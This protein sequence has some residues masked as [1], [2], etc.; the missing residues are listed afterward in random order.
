MLSRSEQTVASP[1]WGT[2][3]ATRVGAP[4]LR[5]VSGRAVRWGIEG[6]LGSD[7]AGA[8]LVLGAAAALWGCAL[9]ALW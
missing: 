5:A 6:S 2:G 7:V 8:A 4:R 1:S 3:R 9:A